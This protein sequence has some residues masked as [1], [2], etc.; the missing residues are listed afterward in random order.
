MAPAA[1][2]H[3]SQVHQHA[4]TATALEAVGCPVSLPTGCGDTHVLGDQGLTQ[5]TS[6]ASASERAEGKK[7]SAACSR[8]AWAKPPC[9]KQGCQD[10]CMIN[11]ASSQPARCA[12]SST[13]T[14]ESKGP[15][16]VPDAPHLRSASPLRSQ[17]VPLKGSRHHSTRARSMTSPCRKA[18]CR[19]HQESHTG[20]PEPPRRGAPAGAPRRPWAAAMSPRPAA[21]CSTRSWP[22][23]AR[24]SGRTCAPGPAGRPRSA[25]AASAAPA[26]PSD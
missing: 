21:R 23:T 4:Q 7:A 17:H 19:S 20:A 14:A 24:S 8:G 6:R 16:Y 15:H 3:T 9:Q 25:P 1:L 26:P 12:S 18:A 10:P 13:E 2:C 22:R 5:T 11:K